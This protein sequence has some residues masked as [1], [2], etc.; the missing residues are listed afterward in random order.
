MFPRLLG[1]RAKIVA[2]SLPFSL[3]ASLPLCPSAFVANLSTCPHWRTNPPPA[4][5]YRWVVQAT[6]HR[7]TT[8]HFAANISRYNVRSLQSDAQEVDLISRTNSLSVR[9]MASRASSAAAILTA[10]AIFAPAVAA[11]TPTP[12]S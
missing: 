7:R 2:G 4:A 8:Q 3:F 9:G 1:N 11:Q 10:F 6:A 5:S 12:A